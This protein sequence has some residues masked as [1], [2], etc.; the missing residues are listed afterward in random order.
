MSQKPNQTR[1]F[2]SNPAEPLPERGSTPPNGQP[3]ATSRI[4][5]QF[6]S[7]G[8]AIIDLGGRIVIGRAGGEGESPE[9]GLDLSP[10]GAEQSGVSRVHAAFS[11]QEGVVY[12]EDLASTNGTRINGFQLVPNRTYRLRDG[13]ELEFG[14]ARLVVR[15]VRSPR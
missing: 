11:Y 13:D 9:I 3:P 4:A 2:N 5:L 6:E 15:F 7:G 1:L 8:R 14:R 12:I 10:Y